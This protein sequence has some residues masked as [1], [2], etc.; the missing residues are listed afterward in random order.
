MNS[1]KASSADRRYSSG[2]FF[3]F[4]LDQ[5]K[6]QFALYIIIMLL[7]MIL[8]CLF[9]VSRVDLQLKSVSA[10]IQFAEEMLEMVAILGL[11]ASFIISVFAGMGAISYVNSKKAVGCYHSFPVRRE[12]IFLS[13]T[14]TR[15]IF[16]IISISIGYLVAYF[17]IIGAVPQGVA[18]T[19]EFLRYAFCS[20]ILFMYVYSIML[21]AAGMCGTGF[22][23]FAMTGIIVFLP[24]VIYLLVYSTVE[25]G[26]YNY[27]NTA[28][29][30][31][32]DEN[33]RHAF[34]FIRVIE[35][36]VK[37][38]ESFLG[39]LI[40]TAE[41]LVYYVI[42]LILHKYRHSE[43]SETTVIWKPVFVGVKYALIIASALLG[44]Y[45][46]GSLFGRDDFFAITFGTFLGL[47]ISLLAVN[48]IMYRS[49]R[50]MFTGIKPFAV[51]CLVMVI[52]IFFVP[53]NISG[54]FGKMY[55]PANTSKLSIQANGTDIEYTE[56]EDVE[57]LLSSLEE[58]QYGKGVTYPAFS[59]LLGSG[60]SE[61]LA[62]YFDEYMNFDENDKYDGEK[63]YVTHVSDTSG[64]KVIQD[65]KIGAS[66]EFN[67]NIDVHS[68]FFDAIWDTDEYVNAYDFGKLAA[69]GFTV[70]SL[71]FDF[72]STNFDLSS[73]KYEINGHMK[74]GSFLDSEN[75][76]KLLSKLELRAEYVGES[77]LLGIIKLSCVKGEKVFRNFEYPIYA[78]DTE[79]VLAMAKLANTLYYNTYGLYLLPFDM[80]CV[81][82]Y[83]SSTTEIY[84]SVALLHTTTGE[85][86]LLTR[87]ELADLASFTANF[88]D[89]ERTNL[90]TRYM[91]TSESEYMII[92]IRRSK[93]SL[94]DMLSEIRF[95]DGAI[96][97]EELTDLFDSLEK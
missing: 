20:P 6:H 15:A 87:E 59:G 42:A 92:A 37:V 65:P 17:M 94:Y 68:K 34:S 57:T 60:C 70:K 51:V 86:K 91:N 9:G 21:V 38:D 40:V 77:P 8:P 89:V 26:V 80:K 33:M 32:F 82:E 28:A 25:M 76:A 50:M 31:V 93:H 41:S 39:V 35:A 53:L 2:P 62:Y 81:D 73:D 46:F 4:T 96:S 48:S 54:V 36:I 3:G 49:T 5:G 69:D 90:T 83:Y 45:V 11:V 27:Y 95:R 29:S 58:S 24:F 67:Y 16:Y 79:V 7:T 47:V 85:A 14:L 55:S 63:Y 75:V 74:R 12:Y 18:F 78:D 84:E 44:M 23:R 72:C 10:R 61:T 71:R 1:T 97:D 88:G 56:R 30:Y 43:Q 19:G 66:L 22:M 64:V 13:E 52:Y